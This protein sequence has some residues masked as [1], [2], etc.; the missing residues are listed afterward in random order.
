MKTLLWLDDIRNPYEDNWLMF[1]PIENPNITWV[2]SYKEFTTWIEFFGLP[3][4]ICFDHD[5]GMEV[6]LKARS[7]GMSKR[8]SR[9]LKQ[10]EKTGYDCAKWL[11]DY[12]LD[13]KLDLPLYN[14]Q[15][16][17]PVGKE[18]IDRLLKQFKKHNYEKI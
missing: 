7:K 18:N 1:S 3:D 6:V 4:A 13:N 5:L 10:Q 2:K 9:K 16:A 8:K 12:C 14:I 15:S 17:N 11:V